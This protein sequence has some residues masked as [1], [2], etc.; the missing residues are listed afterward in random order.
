MKS[1][2]DSIFKS[3]IVLILLFSSI[4]IFS[5]TNSSSTT[6]T[7]IAASP[8]YSI[9]GGKNVGATGYVANF[10]LNPAIGQDG[11]GII[12]NGGGG[13]NGG[14]VNINGANGYNGGN[15]TLTPG[16]G[17]TSGN[18]ILN[19][20]GT[21]S[22]ILGKINVLSTGAMSS[23]TNLTATG[24]IT[25]N[26]FVG[27]GA[28]LTSAVGW[29]KNGSNTYSNG[30]VGIGTSNPQE[31]LQFG[32]RFVI[33][34]SGVKI[35]GYNFH[36]TAGGNVRLVTGGVSTIRMYEGDIYFMTAPTGAAGSIIPANIGMKIDQNGNVGIGKDPETKLDVNGNAFF[37]SGT[38]SK[39]FIRGNSSF[40]TATTPD[41]TWWGNDQTGLFHPAA[42][43][44]G[45]SI[46]GTENMRITGSGIGIGTSNLQGY[47]L[48]VN[49]SI[50]CKE[51][52]VTANVPAS[53]YVFE[54]GYKPATLS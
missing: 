13:Y 34:N 2:S 9:Y 29:T 23:I 30:N 33:H 41:Y 25:A 54:E 27:N 43:I 31:A 26:S 1:F 37:G 28:G 40:S 35:I 11:G 47:K 12:L 39:A 48:A 50:I 5:Q 15:I 36:Y 46:G 20:P 6:G 16:T 45:F 24:T 3:F 19:T 14:G 18:I 8:T 22:I 38:V 42:N 32:D 7:P 10:T 51:V 44:I 4:T 52:N 53:D 17:S 49:G 21:S